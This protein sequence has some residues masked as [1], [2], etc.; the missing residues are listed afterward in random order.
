MRVVKSVA[1]NFP[2]A[3]RAMKKLI[4]KIRQVPV[5]RE[6]DLVVRATIHDFDREAWDSMFASHAMSRSVY[7]MY[8][9]A[10]GWEEL[11]LGLFREGTLLGGLLLAVR[12]LPR[13]PFTLS[14]VFAVLIGPNH[15]DMLRVLL[16]G[17]DDLARHLSITETEVNARLPMIDGFEGAERTRQ[18]LEVFERHRYSKLP[19]VDRSYWVRIDADDDE[20][21]ASFSPPPRNRI[22]KAQKMGAEAFCSS[23]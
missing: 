13:V 6:S 14:R 5:Y 4:E 9:F 2:N 21:L 23:D 16:N 10:S 18:M 7:P 15:A 22:K 11:R 20:L 19:R 17:Y 3:R 8:F 12:S 1:L